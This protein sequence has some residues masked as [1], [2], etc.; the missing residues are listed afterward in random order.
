[1][2]TPDEMVSPA[3]LSSYLDDDDD[4]FLEDDFFENYAMNIDPADHKEYDPS[5][6]AKE[7][8]HL[9]KQQQEELSESLKKYGKL[10]SG[11]LGKYEGTKVHLEVHKDA[12]PKHAR[13][14]SIPRTQM[15]LF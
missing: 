15:D 9:T 12:V 13:P 1:M 6:V 7:Q 2:K 11:Q 5:E 3:S 14:Y 8:T 4:E 10:F